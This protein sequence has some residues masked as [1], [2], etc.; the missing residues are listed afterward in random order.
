[1]KNK[2]LVVIGL[3]FLVLIIP[4]VLYLTFSYS[5]TNEAEGL[6]QPEVEEIVETKN[7][8][9]TNVVYNEIANFSLPEK[10][11]G[12]R[13]NP[14]TKGKGFVFEKEGKSYIYL[15]YVFSTVTAKPVISTNTE[16]N[17]LIITSE[18]PYKDPNA[19]GLTAMSYHNFEIE[20]DGDFDKV[21][22]NEIT[23]TVE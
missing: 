4:F 17:D 6:G 18:F 10:A 19:I 9:V 13:S 1:M 14:K 2:T 3:T 23:K 22:L 11:I 15:V 7:F 8:E 16:G 21:I 12:L 20:V 5:I